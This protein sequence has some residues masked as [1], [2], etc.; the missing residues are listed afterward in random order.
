MT[1]KKP[2]NES[3]VQVNDRIRVEWGPARKKAKATEELLSDQ[4]TAPHYK[5]GTKDALGKP[6]K[7]GEDMDY[8][9]YKADYVWYIYILQLE[10][11]PLS[12]QER[13]LIVG[14]PEKDRSDDQKQKLKSGKVMNQR[15]VMV[16]HK[17]NRDE[18]MAEAQKLAGKK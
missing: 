5:V 6:I 17:A 7:V 8:L 15:Y 14:K 1:M 2:T 11:G 3:L 16:G 10:E 13:Q 12:D 18:A 9:D 4:K